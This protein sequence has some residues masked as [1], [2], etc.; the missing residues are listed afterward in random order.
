MLASSSAPVDPA[1]FNPLAEI[2]FSMGEPDPVKLEAHLVAQPVADSEP[3]EQL[4]QATGDDSHQAMADASHQAMGDDSH[5]AMGDDTHQAMGADSHQAMGAD[6][7]QGMGD[8]THEAIGANSHPI[9][10]PQGKAE[11]ETELHEKELMLLDPQEKLYASADTQGQEKAYSDSHEKAYNEQNWQIVALGSVCQ[12]E[13]CKY[14]GENGVSKRMHRHCLQLTTTGARCTYNTERTS[15]LP[16]HDRVHLKG[17]L[18][19][20]GELL[21]TFLVF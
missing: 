6:S 14:A 9:A 10:E 4:H 16:G 5:Q 11:Q 19:K 1:T 13:G 20:E 17:E 18:E 3:Q 12:L 8:N 15:N 21:L 7:H 2:G